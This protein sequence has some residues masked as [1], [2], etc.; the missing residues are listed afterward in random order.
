MDRVKILIEKI[1]ARIVEVREE[2]NIS[3]AE[4]SKRSDIDDGSLRRIETG[5]TNP[6]VKTLYTIAEALEVKVSDLIDD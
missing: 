1:G 2:K 6:T 3:Q 4:L 5:R